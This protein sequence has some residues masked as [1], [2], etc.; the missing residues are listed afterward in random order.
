MAQELHFRR[1]A[2][3]ANVAQPALSRS[4]QTLEAELGVQLLARNNRNVRLTEAGKEFL[5]GCIDIV[6]TMDA[7]ISKS[8]RAGQTEFGGLNIGYTYIAM[9][10]ELP[11]L[12]AEFEQKH[13]AI[14]IEPV[15]ESSVEQLEQ[16]HHRE[17]DVCFLSGPVDS[18]EV[19]STVFQNDEFVV[20]ANLD[21]QHANKPSIS[22][23]ELSREK[24]LL[25]PDAKAHCF[26]QHVYEFFD[27]AG[28]SPNFEYID[29]DHIGLLGKVALN[30]GVCIATAGYGCVYAENLS[31]I[32]LVG[33]RKTMPTIMAWHKD[34]HS[35]SVLAFREFIET[36]TRASNTKST[37]NA[38]TG[39][40]ELS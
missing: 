34:T 18:H 1:A 7:T 8:V 37:A 22:V 30:R 26:N 13:P 40:T 20:I 3:L 4:V 6:E 9:C 11:K 24:I 38:N 35:D 15:G 29:Q 32:K 10:G 36:K 16:L 12:L 2:Q 27:E 39:V 14:K 33:T 23:Q 25:R 31:T 17:L 21:N 28:L 19:D 5:A